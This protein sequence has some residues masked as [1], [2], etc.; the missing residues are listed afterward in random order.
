VVERW[1]GVV[2][3]LEADL[4]PCPSTPLE[5]VH[6]GALEFPIGFAEFQVL[7]FILV[8]FAFAHAQQDLDT[9]VF[10]IE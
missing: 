6:G 3:G 8:R 7:T 9:S 2:L 10:P 1:E 5:L 4:L